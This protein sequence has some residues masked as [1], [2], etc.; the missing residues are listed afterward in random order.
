MAFVCKIFS[1]EKP[2]CFASMSLLNSF[3]L[4]EVKCALSCFIGKKLGKGS[5]KTYKT[6]IY[7]K[8]YP[9]GNRCL[10]LLFCLFSCIYV[11]LEKDQFLLLVDMSTFQ[12]EAATEAF[13]NLQSYKFWSCRFFIPDLIN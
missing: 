3:Y 10:F 9:G 2:N 13:H 8:I 12:L 11:A 6:Y 5:L 1:S 7:I 4:K